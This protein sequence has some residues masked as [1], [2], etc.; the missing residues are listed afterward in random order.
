MKN[1]NYIIGAI[2]VVAIGAGL[3]VSGQA[4]KPELSTFWPGTEV[5]CIPGHENLAQHIHPVLKT[6]IDGA[7]VPVPANIGI[8]STCMA[9]IHTHDASGMIHIETIAAGKT[10]TMSDFFSVVGESMMKDG[11]TLAVTVNGEAVDDIATRPL[12]D[13]DQIVLNYTAAPAGV[14]Q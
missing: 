6:F 12:K 8:S 3:F 5:G 7:E 10:F 11:Y 2:V 13:H 9:E 14:A 4:A 1:Q